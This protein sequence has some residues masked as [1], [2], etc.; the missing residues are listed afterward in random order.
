MKSHPSQ[1][2]PLK[3][4]LEIY[5]HRIKFPG[6]LPFPSKW[7][8]HEVLAYTDSDDEAGADPY[9]VYLDER[10]GWQITLERIFPEPESDEDEP[11]APISL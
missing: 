10:K 2:A 1:A 6:R 7:K 8:S 9:Y 4:E 11:D 3:I 5:G